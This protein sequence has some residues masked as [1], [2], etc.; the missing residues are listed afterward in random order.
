MKSA[1]IPKGQQASRV[2]VSGNTKR[3]GNVEGLKL[4]WDIER[5]LHNTYHQT[6]PLPRKNA[7]SIVIFPLDIW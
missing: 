5:R 4:N 7:P 1:M 2:V 3:Y 6:F